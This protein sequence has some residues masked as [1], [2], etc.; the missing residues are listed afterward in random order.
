MKVRENRE[1][2]RERERE[3]KLSLLLAGVV[4]FLLFLPLLLTDWIVL[5]LI[6]WLPVAVPLQN[7]FKTRVPP[8]LLL[9]A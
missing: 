5:T 9:L 6:T 3:R 4:C 1:I 7:P 8:V 2:E